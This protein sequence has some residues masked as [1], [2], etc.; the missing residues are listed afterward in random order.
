MSITMILSW[1]RL[2]GEYNS[3]SVFSADSL[4]VP[5]MIRS[6]RMQSFTA[7][8]SFK[9]SGLD[10]TSNVTDLLASDKV[11]AIL[12]FTLSA[13]PT[14]TVDL[15]ITTLWDAICVAIVSATANTYLRSAEPSS[16]GGVPTAIK[17]TSPCATPRAASV[18]KSTL[19]AS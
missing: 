19:P 5:K 6:G 18:V 17:I 3:R 10:T 15:L 12:A 7:A 2:K 4:S 8:P 1:L 13:V 9:N 14:G 16:S 11:L